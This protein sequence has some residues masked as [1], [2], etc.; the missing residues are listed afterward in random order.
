MIAVLLAAIGAIL[1][2][3]FFGKRTVRAEERRIEREG[4]AITVY[5]SRRKLRPP[6]LPAGGKRGL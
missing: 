3:W 1:L 6:R 5:P 4:S 2:I